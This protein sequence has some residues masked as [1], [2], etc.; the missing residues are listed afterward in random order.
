MR[1]RWD[2]QCLLRPHTCQKSIW[3]STVNQWPWVWSQDLQGG[4]GFGNQLHTFL[5]SSKKKKRESMNGKI[6]VIRVTLIGHSIKLVL[7]PGTKKKGKGLIASSHKMRTMTLYFSFKNQITLPIR[8]TNSLNMLT[9]TLNSLIRKLSKCNGNYTSISHN[10][11]INPTTADIP[12]TK[13]HVIQST[14]TYNT[15]NQ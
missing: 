9:P 10:S 15:N 3:T 7:S 14:K 4:I 1:N 8:L 2:K 5:N 11:S 13:T 12:N 6:L